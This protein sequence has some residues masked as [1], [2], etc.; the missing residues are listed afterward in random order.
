MN[1]KGKAIFGI[2][3][4]VLLCG[5]AIH[6]TETITNIGTLTETS[7]K[8]SEI[9]MDKD[10][11][12]AGNVLDSFYTGTLTKKKSESS[13]VYADQNA[14]SKPTASAESICN[15]EPSKIVLS[16]KVPPLASTPEEKGKNKDSLPLGA[17]VLA[18]GALTVG[19]A[20]R[21]KPR[22]YFDNYAEDAATVWNHITGGNSNSEKTSNNASNTSQVNNSTSTANSNDYANNTSS[23]TSSGS[24]ANDNSSNTIIGGYIGNISSDTP[25][26]DLENEAAVTPHC[27]PWT[28]TCTQ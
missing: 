11:G 25:H 14:T 17:G 20:S 21:T 22:G 2:I 15:A 9:D 5:Q 23:N 24:Y 19:I 8:I 10:F 7:V 6:A 13:V 27:N 26:Y 28:D 12:K 3:G 4:A 1:K 18:V 16:G